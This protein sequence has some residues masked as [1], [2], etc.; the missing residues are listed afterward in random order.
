[1]NVSP[2]FFKRFLAQLNSAKIEKKIDFSPLNP[3]PIHPSGWRV[4]E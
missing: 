2:A 1:V 3:K 4:T